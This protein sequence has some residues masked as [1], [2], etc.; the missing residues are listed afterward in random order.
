MSFRHLY[1]H[2]NRYAPRG[3]A[4]PPTPTPITMRLIPLSGCLLLSVCL[5]A[6]FAPA[7][8]G[9]VR[10]IQLQPEGEI[11]IAQ[12]GVVSRNTLDGL[13]LGDEENIP[14]AMLDFQW[15]GPH[16]SVSTQQGDWSG[17]GTLQAE[18]SEGG[19]TLPIG[20]PVDS[21]LDLAIHSAIITWDLL[22][23]APELGLGFGV[24][25]L[26]LQGSFR[27]QNT[28]DT[29]DFDEMIPIPVLALRANVPFGPFEFGG[30]AAGFQIDYDGDEAQ[31]LDIDIMGRWHF[32]GGDRRASGSLVV[33]YRSI[34]LEVDY[35]GDG[36]ERVDADLDFTG[37]FIGGQL[38]F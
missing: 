32:L 37:P 19:I 13:G 22:P 12:T 2:S 10:F 27:S 31:F 11:G 29:I 16:I 34:A 20:E 30:H 4:L 33:G 28:G 35:E 8:D 25:A 23:G 7:V 17:T 24:D 26:D 6:C 1:D 38:S 15:G 21:T 9:T 5:P 3:P 18:F 14:G 36:G